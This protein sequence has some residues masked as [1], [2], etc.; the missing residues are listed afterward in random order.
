MVGDGQAS[1][2][3]KSATDKYSVFMSV[4]ITAREHGRDHYVG[5]SHRFGE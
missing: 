1:L 4:S 5:K 3:R 2:G